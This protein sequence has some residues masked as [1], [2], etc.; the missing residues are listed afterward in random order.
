[1]AGLCNNAGVASFGRFHETDA[2]QVAQIV[3]LNVAALSGLTAALLPDMVASGEGAVLN[4]GSVL[5]YGPVPHNAAYAATKAFA[6]SLGQAVHAEL[7]GTG[8][9]C[10]TVSPGPVRTE[11]YEESGDAEIEDLG[12]GVLWQDP[13]EVAAAAVD[14]MEEGRRSVIPGVLNK[15][16]AV[17]ERHLPRALTLGVS[18]AVAGLNAQRT[19]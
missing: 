2:E 11:I 1:M 4:V 6:L 15:L 14:A 13:D 10:T 9:S 16:F 3:A 5:A 17:G 12:P 19:R 8:V 7:A 18:V